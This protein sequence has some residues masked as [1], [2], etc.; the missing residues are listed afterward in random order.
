[1]GRKVWRISQIILGVVLVGLAV[2][3]LVRGWD[4]AQAAPVDWEI[5]VWLIGAS[6][7][8]TWAVYALLIY[9]WRNL[10]A[11]WDRRLL[12]REAAR[13]WTVSNLGRYVPG[14]VWTIAGMALLAKRA[15]VAPWAATAGAVLNQVLAVGAGAAIIS[16][17]GASLLKR[18]WPRAEL[19]LWILL[20]VSLVV[21]L[22]AAVPSVQGRLFR[23]AR[24]GTQPAPVAHRALLVATLANLVAWCG[25]GV[26][27]WLLARGTMDGGP[28]LVMAVATFATSS[29][30]GLLALFA[31]AGIGVR[32]SVIFLLLEGSL[33]AP[34]AAAL[35]IAS[36]I[37]LTFTEVGA[38]L[39]F[40][41]SSREHARDAP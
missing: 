15:G 30:A 41:A 18:V 10:V 26:A 33:G 6:V 36:R 16:L 29:L 35:A 3:Q 13:I 9:S 25:Y 4:A 17:T 2:R 34:Q 31:P 23:L 40:L 1:M 39:P 8:L 7:A 24:L 5:N 37:L 19:S 32:E 14:K 21:L 12:L 20:G 38:A 27:F 28:D 11:A 22:L